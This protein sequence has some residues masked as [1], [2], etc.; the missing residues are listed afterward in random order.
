MREALAVDLKGPVRNLVER[1]LF[2]TL[3]VLPSALR[4][5]VSPLDGELQRSEQAF[6]LSRVIKD[7]TIFPQRVR[8]S[9]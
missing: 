8:Q 3:K 9:A 7:A 5:L 4:K 1:P 2:G 6:R